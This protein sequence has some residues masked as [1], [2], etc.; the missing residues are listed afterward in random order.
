M[1]TI[2]DV[3]DRARDDTDFRKQ[4][5]VNPVETLRECGVTLPMGAKA[6]VIET[7]PNEIHLNLG[8]KGGPRELQKILDRAEADSAF[9]D[10]LIENPKTTLEQSLGSVLPD[11]V[12]VCVH[13]TPAI[14]E[15][16]LFL[17]PPNSTAGELSDAE[18]ESVAGGGFLK[19]VMGGIKEFFCRDTKAANINYDTMEYQ[20]V[21]DT[22][23]KATS[24]HGSLMVW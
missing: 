2:Q 19:N 17:S 5:K 14:G 10:S 9:R 3:L 11:N 8:R 15:L 12:R 6:E 4:L 1:S 18:L 23:A 7:E 16:R 22:S 21:T 24:E 20:I 13:Q